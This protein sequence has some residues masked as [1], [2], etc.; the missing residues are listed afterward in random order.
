[1]GNSKVGSEQFFF[2]SLLFLLSLPLYTDLNGSVLCLKAWNLFQK[3]REGAVSNASPES[4]VHGDAFVII[5]SNERPKPEAVVT[6]LQMP[7]CWE[8]QIAH[9][10]RDDNTTTAISHAW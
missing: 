3:V 5:R 9:L 7:I 1:M 2:F 6:P 10:R 4:L 8:G